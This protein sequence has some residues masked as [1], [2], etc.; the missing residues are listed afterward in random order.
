LPRNESAKPQGGRAQRPNGFIPRFDL[1]AA[2]GGF[3]LDR[4]DQFF[5][6]DLELMGAFAEEA[7][8][9]MQ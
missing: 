3:I 2:G 8:H 4:S 5:E 1:T 6:A 9:R 7:R